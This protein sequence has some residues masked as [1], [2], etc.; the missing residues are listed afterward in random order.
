MTHAGELRFGIDSM[1]GCCAG[2]GVL[3]AWA[4]TQ[5]EVPQIGDVT[6]RTG[7][8]PREPHGIKIQL[9]QNSRPHSLLRLPFPCSHPFSPRKEKDSSNKYRGS[10]PIPNFLRRSV[11][12]PSTPHH[13]PSTS[14]CFSASLWDSP[15]PKAIF[16]DTTAYTAAFSLLRHIVSP[17]RLRDTLNNIPPPPGPSNSSDRCAIFP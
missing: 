16:L 5:W 17:R 9:I 7:R 8:T 11:I 12:Y 13:T 10:P 4:G 14:S 15:V 2:D 1:L 6:G 3:A